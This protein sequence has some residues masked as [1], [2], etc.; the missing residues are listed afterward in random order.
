MIH[1][2]DYVCIW[3]YVKEQ[4]IDN[5][6]MSLSIATS[7]LGSHPN[8]TATDAAAFCSHSSILFSHLPQ[9]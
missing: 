1:G 8:S 7:P 5:I 2:L 9:K 4:Q 6:Q 3:F